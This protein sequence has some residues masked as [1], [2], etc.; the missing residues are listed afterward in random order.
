MKLDAISQIVEFREEIGEERAICDWPFGST[1]GK[2]TAS[3]ERFT[4]L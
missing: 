4:K 3:F 1:Y 2:G